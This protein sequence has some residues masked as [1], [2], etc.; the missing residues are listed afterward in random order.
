MLF[1]PASLNIKHDEAKGTLTV[2]REGSNG[3]LL[4]QNARPDF[5]P[6]LHPI[7]A[8]DGKG[9]LTEYSPGHH[10]HQTGLY[11]G[12]TRVNGRD[13][14]HH[15]E[16][17]YWKRISAKVLKGSGDTVSWETVYH[18]LGK[19]GEAVLQET[20]HWTLQDSGHQYALDLVWRGKALKPVTIGKYDYGGLFL[21][22][23]WKK[24]LAGGVVN[25]RGQHGSK[26]EGQRANW[27]DVGMEIEG[28]KD[29]GRIS[30][31]DHRENEGFP[32]AWRV[33]GQ[34]GVGPVRARTGDWQIAK[35]KEEVI[36][37]RII[38]STGDLEA[39][40]LTKQWQEYSEQSRDHRLRG[41][42]Q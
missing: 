22:M 23:P 20:Q 12:F 6:F 37:H 33:D 17:D 18:L 21:R 9:I 40:A 26:A 36:K 2:Y 7:V 19:N 38:V 32:Q 11:W 42:A 3:P 4:T 28:R 29:Q 14:F 10:K 30:I 34:L 25:G 15:P 35:G 27:I 13:Y 31:F 24:G 8:P 39:E 16:G 5:R 1:R 41:K